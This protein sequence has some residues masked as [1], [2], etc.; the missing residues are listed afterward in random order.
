MIAIRRWRSCDNVDLLPEFGFRLDNDDDRVDWLLSSAVE[1]SHG[2][3]SIGLDTKPE[4]RSRG[5]VG[6]SC[7][8]VD[9]GQSRHGLA[10][11]VWIGEYDFDARPML[12]KRDSTSS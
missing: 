5:H 10:R 2:S 8:S 4:Q 9:Q 1:G 7:A 11:S 12:S 3:I 6:G